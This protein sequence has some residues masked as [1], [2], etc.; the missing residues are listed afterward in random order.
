MTHVLPVVF[1]L[2]PAR[3]SAQQ[4]DSMCGVA[5]SYRQC[6]HMQKNVLASPRERGG[7]RDGNE[8]RRYSVKNDHSQELQ[9]FDGYDLDFPRIL[10]WNLTERVCLVDSIQCSVLTTP[11][12]DRHPCYT[13]M[14]AD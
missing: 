2:L 10:E 12:V 6:A 4:Y 9:F 7:L 1:V 13:T 14:S 5:S 8:L 3:V 11:I